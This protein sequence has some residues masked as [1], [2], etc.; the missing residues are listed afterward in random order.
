MGQI[1]CVPLILAGIGFVVVA[2]RRA[3]R[4]WA[5]SRG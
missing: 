2:M 4:P 5:E 1:L 3:P